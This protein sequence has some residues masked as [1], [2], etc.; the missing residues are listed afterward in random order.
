MTYGDK[1]LSAALS[2]GVIVA[3]VACYRGSS[4]ADSTSTTTN[5]SPP[6]AAGTSG[7]SSPAPVPAPPDSVTTTSITLRTDRTSYRA[8][9]PVTL[10]I[11]NGS[12]SKFYFN[13][14]TR[15]L[16]RETAGAWTEVREQRM[17]TM[18]AHVLD[19]KA[20]RT[21]QTELGEGL[22][23]GRYRMIVHFTEEPPSGGQGRAVRAV[24][25]PITVTP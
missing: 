15:V 1:H 22:Q 6:P 10:S 13:P 9:D 21:E 19:A 18:I 7:S 12:D 24:T 14:C 20:T 3:L 2:I 25:A 23:P 16:E 17:C 4:A 5:A 8:S 11:V